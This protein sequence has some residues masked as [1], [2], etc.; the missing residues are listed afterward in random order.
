MMPTYV[1]G[2]LLRYRI[3]RANGVYV[4]N[5]GD[6]LSLINCWWQARACPCFPPLRLCVFAI[7]HCKYMLIDIN[8]YS[9]VR[10]VCARHL[11]S[12]YITYI[13]TLACYL[14]G[15][16]VICE[17]KLI[18]CNIVLW[19]RLWCRVPICVCTYDHVDFRTCWLKLE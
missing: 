9:D 1:W 12:T 2:A 8:K 6:D 10:P 13:R 18:W 14:S 19:F 7:L 11:C 3:A 17:H 4:R 15:Q 16:I 5:P